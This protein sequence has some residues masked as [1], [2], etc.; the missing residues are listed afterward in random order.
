M[1]GVSR[2]ELL[3]SV[4]PPD[5]TDPWLGHRFCDRLVTFRKLVKS[6]LSHRL[7]RG[8]ASW[9]FTWTRDENLDGYGELGWVGMYGIVEARQHRG[10]SRFRS[11]RRHRA[12]CVHQSGEQARGLEVLWCGEAIRCWY[13][14]ER[15]CV[16]Y[17]SCKFAENTVN[18]AVT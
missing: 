6:S 14:G 13:R 18:S 4:V 17:S 1:L 15:R 5:G 16:M 11:S 9:G 12:V 3:L 7:H 8:R 2:R 10:C